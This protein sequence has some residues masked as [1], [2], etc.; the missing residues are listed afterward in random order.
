MA[1]LF[2]ARRLGAAGFSRDVAI[3][4]VHPELASDAQFRAMFLDEA[5]LSARIQH[6]N[7]GHVEELGEIAGTHFLVMEFV[8]GCSLAQLQ[9]A[10]IAKG[11]R[12]APAF[13][14]RIAMHVAEGLHA[15]HE[16][17]DEHGRR[18]DVVHRDVSPENILLAYAGHVKLIDF[19]IAKAYGRRHRTED[20]LLKGKFRYMSPEQASGQPID[21]RTDVYQLGIVLW[22]MLTLRRLFDAETDV[23]LLNQV[24]APRI[25]P[26]SLLVDRI[27]PALEAVV[28]A[29]LDPSA[30]RRIPDAQTFARRL[31]KAMPS[32]HEVDSGALSALLLALMQEQRREQKKTYPS[33]LYDQLEQQVPTERAE[34]GSSDPKGPVFRSYTLEHT[35]PYGSD[36]PSPPPPRRRL[37]TTEPAYAG[38]GQDP[39][40]MPPD[41]APQGPRQRRLVRLA[42]GIRDTFQELGTTITQLTGFKSPVVKA[43]G[44][45]ALGALSMGIVLVGIAFMLRRPAPV[46]SQV[47]V[48]AP[49]PAV[50]LALPRLEQPPPAK[51]LAADSEL[52][53]R[54]SAP[55][56]R[57][58]APLV[59]TPVRTLPAEVA[60]QAPA[61]PP[62]EAG[63]AR[64][65]TGSERAGGTERA[66]APEASE[67]PQRDEERKTPAGRLAA[68]VVVDGTPIIPEPGF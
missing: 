57:D 32:A 49:L 61:A 8:H 10:L 22:E 46:P 31:G 33:G 40:R 1:S 29:A 17:C 7:V 4:I 39:V 42:S 51:A 15:A 5:L 30:A 3:K 36:A 58:S 47:P 50:P 35:S 34:G 11:R 13:A 14:T 55:I 65:A 59:L 53:S 62:V 38:A 28:M 19:G 45:V 12:L 54:D 26:P 21:R 2:L 48:P 25:A 63:A 18:L 56:A 68:P 52:P 20:G 64:R 23:D 44:M 6:P 43:L 16:T 9:R 66:A 41:V 24:R 60:N 37:E 27:S 67:R